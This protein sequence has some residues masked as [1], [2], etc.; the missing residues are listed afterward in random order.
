MSKIVGKEVYVITESSDFES[1][2][3]IVVDSWPGLQAEL[4]KSSPAISGDVLQVFHGY[5]TPALSL[6]GSFK[7]AAA[8]VVVFDPHDPSQAVVYESAGEDGVSIAAEIEQLLS[9]EASGEDEDG[10]CIDIDHTF[11]LYGY[12]LETCITV[13]EDEVD[14]EK[15]EKCET[16]AKE[17]MRGIST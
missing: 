5:L 15:I 2:E 14:E 17:A 13:A 4:Q 6:P 3:T 12:Q 11:I 7:G 9:G 8:F 10:M 1:G 16:V